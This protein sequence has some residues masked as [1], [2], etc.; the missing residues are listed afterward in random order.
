[1]SMST[2]KLIRAKVAFVAHLLPIILGFSTLQAAP[3]N[4]DFVFEDEPGT[5]FFDPTFGQQAQETLTTAGDIWGRFLPQSFPGETITVAAQFVDTPPVGIP[6][7]FGGLGGPIVLSRDFPN[8]VPDTLYPGALVNHLAREDAFPVGDPFTP[9]GAEISITFNSQKDYFFGTNGTPGANQLD[10][11]S[12]ALHEIG[13]GLGFIS[14][15]SSDGSFIHGGPS[16]YDRFVV[17]EFGTPITAMTDAERLA[18]VTDFLG[19]FWSG[20]H[21]VAALD[22]T[23]PGLAAADGVFVPA[24]S[25][26]HFSEGFFLPLG[27]GLNDILMLSGGSEEIWVMHTPDRLTLGVLED[28]GWNIA[29]P[30]P[31]PASWSLFAVGLIGL[32]LLQWRRGRGKLGSVF[33]DQWGGKS[34]ERIPVKI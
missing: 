10:F 11:L 3:I 27:L 21:G 30:V 8:S 23:R 18:A 14:E 32:G 19:L 22:G 7:T 28:I 1:M 26:G 29:T 6:D 25:I 17:D 4:F 13:H 24:V 5:G 31:E 16:I 20:E 15:L 12:L 33:L 2:Y 9:T 34:L